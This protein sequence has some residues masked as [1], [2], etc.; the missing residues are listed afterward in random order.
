[1]NAPA[2]RPTTGRSVPPSGPV[3][4]AH[5]DD[6]ALVALVSLPSIGPARLR[7]LIDRWGP[8]GA[9][10]HVRDGSVATDP[11]VAPAL[12]GHAQELANK[13]QAAARRIDPAALLDAHRAL[14]VAMSLRGDSRFPGVFD[15]D[16]T[17]PQVLFGLG[18]FALLTRRSVAIIGTRQCTR[19]GHDIARKLGAELAEAGINVV[20]GLALGIDGAAHRGVL[21]VAETSATGKAIAVVGS[22]L[23]V[24]Y[25][26]RNSDIWHDV[27][28]RGLLLSEAPLGIKPEP[29]RFPARNRIIAALA[30]VVIVVESRSTGGSLTT[31][32]EAALRGRE[33][34]AVPGP[35]TAAASAGTNRLIA[36]GATPLLE[37]DDVFDL[38]GGR[39][40]IPP[41][42]KPPSVQMCSD[43]DDPV[44]TA[45]IDALLHGPLT[46][47]ELRHA[48][49][50]ELAPLALA[51][52]ELELQGRIA[53]TGGFFE[54]CQR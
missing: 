5:N 24:V 32:E 27:A 47:A 4:A 36:E 6:A 51:L 45:T 49:N 12:R 21:Q 15:H 10:R 2:E 9:W 54:A 46:L 29:W 16:P 53:R 25:P 34:M 18:D 14:G 40:P 41:S 35:I 39:A 37:T 33:V 22:G 52:T 43:L 3:D 13:W 26:R 28:A 38:L 44:A 11:I 31:V 48:T 42:H 8:G 1:M 19:Y 50:C 17:P 30:E 23:D 7:V 20:S